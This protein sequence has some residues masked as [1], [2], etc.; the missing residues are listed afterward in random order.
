MAGEPGSGPPPY[1]IA[2]EVI[3]PPLVPPTGQGMN[4]DLIALAALVAGSLLWVQLVITDASMPS[5]QR[6][7]ETQ[8]LADY[9]PRSDDW[10]RR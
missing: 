4:E 8:Y 2:L 1:P 10:K 9:L 6:E 3:P 7:R 5:A